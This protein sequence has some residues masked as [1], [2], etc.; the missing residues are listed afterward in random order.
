MNA[1]KQLELLAIA[2]ILMESVVC[3]VL[4]SVT[5]IS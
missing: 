3:D 2:F 5:V 4:V 1:I